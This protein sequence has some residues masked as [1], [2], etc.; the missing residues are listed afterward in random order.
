M[1]TWSLP[2]GEYSHDMPGIIEQYQ[3]IFGIGDIKVIIKLLD[4]IATNSYRGHHPCPRGSGKRL[5]N[6]HGMKLLELMKY[7]TSMEFRIEYTSLKRLFRSKAK[8]Q[9]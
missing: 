6:C 9:G 8:Y 7:Q 4:I 1:K 3:D 5:R 2:T